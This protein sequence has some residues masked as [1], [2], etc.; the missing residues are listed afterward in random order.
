MGA[1]LN[2]QLDRLDGM[3]AA[4]RRERRQILEGIAPLANLGRQAGADEQP[5]P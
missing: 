4:M 5:G 1:M 3:V 2:V